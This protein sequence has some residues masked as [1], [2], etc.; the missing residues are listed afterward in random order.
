MSEKMGM[1]LLPG[2]SG[3]L[4]E[5]TRVEPLAQ[6]GGPCSV[7]LCPSPAHAHA[8]SVLPL[9]PAEVQ[10]ESD[11]ACVPRL[12]GLGS[13]PDLSLLK[14]FLGF[15][16]AQRG[17]SGHLATDCPGSSELP[18]L[19]GLLGLCHHDLLWMGPAHMQAYSQNM[20]AHTRLHMCTG[21]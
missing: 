14:V 1:V 16:T 13:L 7:C 10:G 5:I 18:F 20:P 3:G 11:V 2:L 17:P 9:Q 21:P 19:L 6:V 12:A 4:N 15:P 8:L